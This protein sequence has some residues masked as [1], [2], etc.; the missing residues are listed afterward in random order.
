MDLVTN[1]STVQ[2]NVTGK[3]EEEEEEEEGTFGRRWLVVLL[4]CCAGT[5]LRYKPGVIVGGVHAFD[6][7]LDRSIGYYLEGLV[8]LAPFAKKPFHLTLTGITNDDRDISVRPPRHCG[9]CCLV[10]SHCSFL[11]SG[12]GGGGGRWTCS[13]Q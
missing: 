7:G 6:C 8:C 2:I 11:S 10:G 4:W 5:Q 9:Y 12:G 1:G 3:E 13:G